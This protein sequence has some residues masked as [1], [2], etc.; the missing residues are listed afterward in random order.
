VTDEFVGNGIRLQL[1]LMATSKTLFFALA[2]LAI[3][4]MAIALDARSRLAPTIPS[5]APRRTM[6]SAP[7][8]IEAA[9]EALRLRFPVS[10]PV[11]NVS[12]VEGQVVQAGELLMRIDH[13]PFLR[14]YE[15]ADAAL[16]V[17][18]S[19]MRLLLE[20]A[21]PE[22]LSH[23]QAL[24]DAEAA[25]VRQAEADLERAR[26]LRYRE[27][28]TQE[29][30]DRRRSL[31][32]VLQAKVAAAKAQIDLLKA[33][34]RL[35]D[36]QVAKANVDAA[37]A[38]AALARHAL[39]QTRLRAPATG[40]VLR[41]NGRV[42]ELTGPHATE[43]AVIIADSRQFTA[44]AFVDSVDAARVRA[45]MS[46]RISADGEDRQLVARVTR[47]SPAVG[48]KVMWTGQPGERFD[49]DVREV[50]LEFSDSS[51]LVL[52]LRVEVAID[53]ASTRLPEVVAGSGGPVLA[54][55]GDSGNILR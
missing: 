34:P 39:D 5:V 22:E 53:T 43:P 28:A 29:E 23:A 32:Q 55:S 30:F 42:G 50:W 12:V 51:D 1:Y 3:G 7:G 26:E 36:V 8:R 54:P 49:S 48:P 6:I 41:I 20:G 24:C 18:Q 31:L 16:A 15:R 38:T 45:G 9:G 2:V 17:A 44:R 47:V 19:N 13:E 35:E 33:P 52:G 40:Q 25:E 37:R 10:G 4:L 46:A 27:V 11:V 14:E 21:R